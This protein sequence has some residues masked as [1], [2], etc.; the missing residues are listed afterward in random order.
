MTAGSQFCGGCGLWHRGSNCASL[1]DDREFC[2][3]EG[4]FRVKGLRVKGFRVEGF[5]V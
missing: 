2:S 4:R 5:R 3:E 1:R